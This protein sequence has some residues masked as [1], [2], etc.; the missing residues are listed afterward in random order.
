MAQN[1]E[2]L[3]I[4]EV[5]IMLRCSKAH[6]CNVINGKVKGVTRLPAIS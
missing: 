6:V 1:P 2:I 3:T 5:A 4:T